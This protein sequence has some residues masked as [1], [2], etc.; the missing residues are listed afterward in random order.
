MQALET[1]RTDSN[2]RHA[3]SLATELNSESTYLE[4]LCGSESSADESSIA[5]VLLTR[6]PIWLACACRI[7][8]AGWKAAR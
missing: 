5:E 3:V 2:K 8:A 4:R 6:L 7:F 1:W